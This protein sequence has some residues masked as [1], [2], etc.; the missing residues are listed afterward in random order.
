MILK[1]FPMPPTSNRLLA[2][3]NGRLIKTRECRD[4][5]AKVNQYKLR[6]FKILEEIKIEFD[7]KLIVIDSFFVFSKKRLISKEGQI[8]KLDAS[9]RIKVAHDNLSRIADLDD[10]NFV[11]GFFEKLYCEHEKDEQVIFKLS[12]LKCIRNFDEL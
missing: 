8:K 10:K 6:N 5:D 3:Y 4:Y 9:N 11:C 12:E 2:P 1:R 7:N